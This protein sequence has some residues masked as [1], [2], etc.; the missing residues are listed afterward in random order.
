MQNEQQS[1]HIS[2]DSRLSSKTKTANS[3]ILSLEQQVLNEIIMQLLVEYGQPNI[4]RN[5]R[6]QER[7]T[8]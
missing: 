2:E 7:W 5:R 6:A 8:A 3:E 4:D 1:G